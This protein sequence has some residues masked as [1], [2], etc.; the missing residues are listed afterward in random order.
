MSDYVKRKEFVYVQE[1][2]RKFN[3]YFSSLPHLLKRGITLA[4]VLDDKAKKRFPYLI[5]GGEERPFIIYKDKAVVTI[6]F[7]FFKYAAQ[8]I[9]KDGFLSL[10]EIVAALEIKDKNPKPF[11]YILKTLLTALRYYRELMGNK[12]IEYDKSWNL[13]G[14]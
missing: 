6:P 7:D 1:V 2:R 11:P 10:E 14:K 4:Y 3:F 12:K 8:R 5:Y 13:V 9:A